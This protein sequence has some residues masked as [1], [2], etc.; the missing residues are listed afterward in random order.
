MN[1]I[2][3]QTVA[4]LGVALGGAASLRALVRRFY[5]IARPDEWLLCVRDGRLV[6]A[7]VGTSVL[8]R[9][10]DVA[11]RFSATMQRVA[12]AAEAP[13]REGIAVRVEGFAF[14]SVS[15]EGDAPFRAYSRLGIADP[16]RAPPGL[17]HEQHTLTSPK[18]KAF[19][20][21]LSAVVQ[22]HAS[23]LPLATLLGA[24]DELVAG[25]ATRIRE[26]TAEMGVRIDH[27]E[28]SAARPADPAVQAQ[29]AVEESV[30][31]RERSERV[32]REAAER[33]ATAKTEANA[34]LARE[35]AE[36]ERALR[37]EAI[38][39]ERSLGLA[40]AASDLEIAR[41][42]M[43]L[44]REESEA[45]LARQRAEAEALRD[46]EMARAE[47]LERMSPAVREHERALRVAE[48]M[49]SMVKVTDAR[50]VSVGDDGPMASVGAM[51][52]GAREALAAASAPRG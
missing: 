20:Q 50:W 15:D 3:P 52:A 18:H 19:Q 21:M 27:V 7:G 42:R 31:L 4:L 36:A 12:F 41:A 23:S 14:W 51:L 17:R 37:E 5:V 16:H 9:P 39:A 22:R 44:E 40:R 2:D 24:Q 38:A 6:H 29:R 47:A 11:V 35:R 33:S 1:L 48:Q 43:A 28:V 30:R 10:G 13:S 25:L 26:V 49:A 8:R 45:R 34:R 32:E 46:A